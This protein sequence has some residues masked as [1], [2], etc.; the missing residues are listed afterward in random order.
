M[1]GNLIGRIIITCGAAAAVTAG[2]LTAVSGP[3]L[4]DTTPPLAFVQT[5]HDFGQVRLGVPKEASFT[6]RNDGAPTHVSFTLTG[7]AEYTLSGAN[8]CGYFLPSRPEELMH[9]QTCVI[10]VMFDP[11]SLGQETAQLI[12]TD[13]AGNQVSA[14]IAGTGSTALFWTNV[15][16]GSSAS[17]GEIMGHDLNGGW[18]PPFALI[19]GQSSPV[20]IVR[21]GGHLYWA[22][23][24]GTIMEA[25][26]D[27]SGAHVIASGQSQPWGVTADNNHLYW[28]NEGNGT[29]NSGTIMEANLDGTGAHAIVTGQTIPSGIAVDSGHLYWADFGPG[30]IMTAS[31]YGTGAHAIVTGQFTPDGVALGG[32]GQIYWTSHYNGTVM[33]ASLD[34]TGVR[35]LISGQT[36]PAGV[37]V[38][39]DQIY[40]IDRA[41]AINDPNTGSIMSARIDGSHVQTIAG[42]QPI[43]WGLTMG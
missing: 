37:A 5:S 39:G 42:G 26:V 10:S 40:W 19:T 4:A 25:N 6:L 24:S 28:T 3:A 8:D 30:T 22:N 20:G 36:S 32:N 16:D 41:D 14:S 7:S 35:T 15:V 12:V 34:G 23:N 17:A 33:A 21:Q 9:G 27:G 31:L 38:D 18:P 43:P 13:S 2:L 29:A 1:T 11:W